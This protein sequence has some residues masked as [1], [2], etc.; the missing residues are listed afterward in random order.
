MNMVNGIVPNTTTN[1]LQSPVLAVESPACMKK[2]NA[3]AVIAM[4][5][6]DR[7]NSGFQTSLAA[8]NYRPNQASATRKICT[9]SSAL[10]LGLRGEN[11][12]RKAVVVLQ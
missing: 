3:I 11:V 8:T 4:A 9:Q 10:L 5:V 6:S 1:E 12:Y 7:T 2:G